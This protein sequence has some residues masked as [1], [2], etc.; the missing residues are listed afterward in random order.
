MQERNKRRVRTEIGGADR[1]G[2]RAQKD[3]GTTA[4]GGRGPGR[5]FGCKTNS[6][7]GCT[8]RLLGTFR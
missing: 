4:F 3:V 6:L 2:I 1:P 8:Q 7:S 5:I